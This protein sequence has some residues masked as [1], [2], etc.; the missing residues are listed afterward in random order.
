M[1]STVVNLL[2]EKNGMGSTVVEV[3]LAMWLSWPC[4]GRVDIYFIS[5]GGC[6]EPAFSAR[7]PHTQLSECLIDLLRRPILTGSCARMDL[8]W[9]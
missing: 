6:L 7:C 9:D 1:G 3:L 4:D 2:S 5:A 8:V